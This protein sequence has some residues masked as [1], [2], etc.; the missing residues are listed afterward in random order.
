MGSLASAF[1]ICLFTQLQSWRAGS[2]WLPWLSSDW[3]Q[4]QVLSE[5]LCPWNCWGWWCGGSQTGREEWEGLRWSVWEMRAGQTSLGICRYW[6]G[7]GAEQGTVRP[8]TDGHPLAMTEL[9]SRHSELCNFPVF[10]LPF[11]SCS[12][13]A[14]CS[15]SVPRMHLSDCSWSLVLCCAGA[16]L[17]EASTNVWGFHLK[18]SDSLGVHSIACWNQSHGL[19]SSEPRGLYSTPH[20]SIDFL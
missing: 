9:L 15:T 18:L 20:S 3:E 13:C 4:S 19:V 11:Y 7:S 8:Y 10:R 12:V 1:W 17:P 2:F 6:C 5:P 16:G 14:S